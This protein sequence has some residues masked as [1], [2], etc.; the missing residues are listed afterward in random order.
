MSMRPDPTREPHRD[1]MDV[2]TL[3]PNDGLRRSASVERLRSPP[4]RMQ[5]DAP[6]KH[7]LRFS[8]QPVQQPLAHLA[9]QRMQLHDDASQHGAH[10]ARSPRADPPPTAAMERQAS[11]PRA[12][13]SGVAA[14]EPHAAPHVAPSSPPSPH[15]SPHNLTSAQPVSPARPSHAKPPLPD[16]SDTLSNEDDDDEVAPAGDR[17]TPLP[18][19]RRRR[20][21]RTG[22]TGRPPNINENCLQRRL[23][24]LLSV[25]SGKNSMQEACE[26]Y[27]ISSRTFY[28]WLRDKDRLIELTGCSDA[29]PP[30]QPTP[31]ARR[32]PRAHQTPHTQH[33]PDDRPRVMELHSVR[34]GSGPVRSPSQERVAAATA[35]A[36]HALAKGATAATRKRPKDARDDAARNKRARDYHYSPRPVYQLATYEPA[37]AAPAQRLPYA[38]APHFSGEHAPAYP[39]VKHHE[40]PRYY[41]S[42]MYQPRQHYLPPEDDDQPVSGAALGTRIELMHGRRKVVLNWYPGTSTD[43]IKNAIV[44]KFA[45]HR[46]F[47]WALNN[48]ADEEVLVS[49]GIPSGRYTLIVFNFK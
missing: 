14:S 35:L 37:V 8:P 11:L 4:R 46:D 2:A 27:D 34:R 20:V 7:G 38:A 22:R 49:A 41:E 10:K 3:R 40:P 12:G 19:P 36:S 1:L 29:A 32:M 24:C 21:A 25:E 48:S 42:D 9:V 45:L 16:A 13:A 47:Q 23:E 43:D 17:P 28:R 5:L 44:R 18:A 39:Y 6:P 15:D 26:Q 33:D 31:F 30:V